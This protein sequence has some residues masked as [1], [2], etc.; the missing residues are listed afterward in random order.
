MAA[1]GVLLVM[2][3]IQPS[4]LAEEQRNAS[5]LFKLLHEEMKTNIALKIPDSN[6]V[7]EAMEKVL[8]LDKAYPLP[9]IGT[10][11]DKF[12]SIVKPA[13]WWPEDKTH[14]ELQFTA[15]WANWDGV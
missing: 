5:R 9:L 15:W 8:A 2:N 14:G 6:D 4:Q 11:L 3:K 13:V 12:P 10:M 1:T 7:E